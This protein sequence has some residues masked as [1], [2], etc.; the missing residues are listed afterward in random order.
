MPSCREHKGGPRRSQSSPAWTVARW[1]CWCRSCTHARQTPS[2]P[3]SP[4][5]SAL[6][7]SLRRT[8]GP[9]RP[10]SCSSRAAL[11]NV[12]NPGREGQSWWPASHAS[13]ATLGRH[14][15]HIP[16]RLARVPPATKARR[17]YSPATWPSSAASR[18]ASRR[19][20][21]PRLPTPDAPPEPELIDM[22]PAPASAPPMT[23]FGALHRSA[24]RVRR[25]TTMSLVKKCTNHHH[26]LLSV[27]TR[28]RCPVCGVS[29]LS[30]ASVVF[31]LC[32]LP[33]IP[34]LIFCFFGRWEERWPHMVSTQG[35]FCAQC[36]RARR[37]TD[38]DL[39]SAFQQE[40]GECLDLCTSG[41][42]P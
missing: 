41:N 29:L 11:D 28:A 38:R 33:R 19:R 17:T 14:A 35:D 4:G 37:A 5:R 23:Q 3:S 1:T 31:V 34:R 32:V 26:I 21:A 18:A 8:A 10:R 2:C 22:P 39:E 15:G 16:S 20:R 30:H 12:L 7:T 42:R 27:V 9:R 13:E 40:T 25:R 36:L 24:P 6:I